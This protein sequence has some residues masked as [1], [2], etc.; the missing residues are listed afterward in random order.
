LP[1]KLALSWQGILLLLVSFLLAALSFM[2]G[3]SRLGDGP[4]SQRLWG[5]PTAINDALGSAGVHSTA[6]IFAPA[7]VWSVLFVATLFRNRA[8]A[9]WMA[10]SAPFALYYPFAAG[11]II[12]ACALQNACP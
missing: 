7:M 4:A 8:L 9:F 6:A 5:L 12:M 10:A 3:A 1:N 11:A 2:I